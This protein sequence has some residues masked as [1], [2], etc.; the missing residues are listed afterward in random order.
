M[1]CPF[2]ASILK[3]ATFLWAK[4]L[5]PFHSFEMNWLKPIPIDLFQFDLQLNCGF[6]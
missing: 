4:A 3:L 6:H 2:I 5:N 1:F